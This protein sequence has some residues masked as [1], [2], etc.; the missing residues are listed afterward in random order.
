M[1]TK[2]KFKTKYKVAVITISD[3]VSR[4]ERVDE[5]GKKIMEIF[6]KLNCKISLYKV[7]P[8]EI[9][10]ISQTIKEATDKKKIDLVITTGGTGVSPRDVTPEATRTV[11]EKE[12]PG[13]S[14]I[15]RIGG[16]KLTKY[17]I[18]SRGVAGIRKKSL[19]INLP[20]SL[21]GVKESLKLILPVLEHT[22]D[23]IKGKKV[24]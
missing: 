6:K 21:K 8:D 1:E 5:S 19:I 4:S 10:V 2:L 12:I 23:L 11:V 18:I 24:H 17:S 13:I 7:I 16:Y 20:G 14:E 22:I 9:R 3:S 15:I